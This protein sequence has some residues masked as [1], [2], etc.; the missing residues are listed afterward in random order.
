[1]RLWPM[2]PHLESRFQP[3]D[4]FFERDRSGFSSG[5]ISLSPISH[6]L[7]RCLDFV[8]YFLATVFKKPR[9]IN[10]GKPRDFC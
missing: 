6:C 5:D 10:M 8:I 4:G 7:P 9:A 2:P 1:M 3:G